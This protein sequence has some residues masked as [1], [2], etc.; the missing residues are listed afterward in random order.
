MS[1]IT[2][3]NDS[4]LVLLNPFLPAFFKKCGFTE[5]GSFRNTAAA[6]DAVRSLQYFLTGDENS[7]FSDGDVFLDKLLCGLTPEKPVA[8]TDGKISLSE[9]SAAEQFRFF[10]RRSFPERITGKISDRDLTDTFFLRPGTVSVSDG[11]YKL[12]VKRRSYDILLDCIPWT[13]KSIKFPW[14]KEVLFI[15]W[16]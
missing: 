13:F 12:T 14:M 16:V 5:N 8:W 4:G 15:S 9:R 1:E 6:E 3:I 2:D 11:N 10:I 7:R